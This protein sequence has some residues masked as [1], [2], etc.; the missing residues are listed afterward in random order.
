MF[1]T[2]EDSP[3]EGVRNAIVAGDVVA[4]NKLR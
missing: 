3:V 2:F 1:H 4:M